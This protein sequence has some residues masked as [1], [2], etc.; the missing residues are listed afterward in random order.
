MAE[1]LVAS[2]SLLPLRPPTP[3]A[4]PPQQTVLEQGGQF[5]GINRKVQLK[6]LRW[7]APDEDAPDAPPRCVEALLI[8]KHGGVL[9][10]AGRQQVGGCVG[11]GGVGGR[12]GARVGRGWGAGSRSR[13]RP[14]RATQ[15]PPAPHSPPPLVCAFHHHHHLHPHRLRPW[16]RCSATLCTP[17]PRGGGCCACTPPTATT[18]RSTHRVG[19]VNGWVGGWVVCASAWTE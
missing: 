1:P 2:P 12:A 6:P 15:R 5:A 19:G 14:R 13:L 11:G 16:A 9:T 4:T 3:P 18:S 8:L 7:S 17:S 10:H